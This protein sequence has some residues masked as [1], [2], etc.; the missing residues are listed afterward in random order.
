MRRDSAPATTDQAPF[1]WNYWAL[2]ADTAAYAVIGKILNPSVT[3]TY[4]LGFF[5]QSALLVALIPFILTAGSMVSQLFWANVVTGMVRKKRA[6]VIGTV[7]SRASMLLFLGSAA[8]A[9]S[10]GGLLPVWLFYLALTVYSFTN[11][12]I[13]PIWTTF[14]ARTFPE[15]RGRFLSYAYLTDSVLGVAGAYGMRYVLN[16]FPFPT[17]FVYFFALLALFAL[18]TIAPALLFREVPEVAP[19]PG[20]PV[21]QMLRSVPGMMRAFPAYRRYLTCRIVVTF[22]EMA[23]HFY[24][25]HAV[26]RLGATTDHIAI[27]SIVMVLGGLVGNAVWGRLGDRF[28]FMR[29]FQVAFLIG[30]LNTVLLLLVKSPEGL[31]PVFFLSGAYST[32]I[33]MSVTNLNMATSPAAQ[34]PLFVGLANAVTGPFLALTPLLGALIS[35]WVGYRTLL[36][37]CIGVYVIDIALAQWSVRAPGS[38]QSQPVSAT[39]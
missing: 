6:W 26:Q 3:L 33:M 28:G 24:T 7:I 15:G 37:L 39:L 18:L 27:Y 12:L 17:S 21:W 1:R 23:Q 5:T 13:V 16:A 22:A 31:Y 8:L 11:G 14:I 29:V 25:V 9:G 10:R 19:A 38:D 2:L 20:R 35:G 36:F 30:L 34:M 4:Y 32:C